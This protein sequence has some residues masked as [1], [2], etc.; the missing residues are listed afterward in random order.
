MWVKERKTPFTQSTLALNS[1]P[2]SLVLVQTYRRRY[3]V[4]VYQDPPPLFCL[5]EAPS[6][7]LTLEQPPDKTSLDFSLLDKL[8]VSLLTNDACSRTLQGT[9]LVGY[10]ISLFLFFLFF[11]LW[12][13]GVVRKPRDVLEVPL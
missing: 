11:C 12:Y 3:F 1:I 9:H 10:T 13:L 2:I 4:Y 8:S 6:L 7:G 5:Q